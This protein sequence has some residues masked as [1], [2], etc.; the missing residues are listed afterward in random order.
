M[1]RQMN[2]RHRF[3]LIAL[4]RHFAGTLGALALSLATGAVAAPADELRKLLEPGNPDEA[5]RVAK[6]T[7]DELYNPAFDFYFS[8]A[9]VNSSKTSKGA[10]SLAE[11]GCDLSDTRRGHGAHSGCCGI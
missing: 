1:G 11:S 5:Y 10:L 9:S 2:Q 6:T 8:V 4:R 3:S 7:P